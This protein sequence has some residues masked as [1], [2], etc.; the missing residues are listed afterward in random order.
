[1]QTESG[2]GPCV[3]E[4][5]VW[6]GGRGRHP[7]LLYCDT[8]GGGGGGGGIRTFYTVIQFTRQ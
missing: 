6:G 7:N 2:V 4:V 1:M 3:G 5:C 8:G